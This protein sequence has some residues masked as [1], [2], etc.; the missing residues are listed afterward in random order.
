MVSIAL[1]N[2]LTALISATIGQIDQSHY[3]PWAFNLGVKSLDTGTP[4]YFFFYAGLMLATA[5][6]FLLIL[7]SY[8]EKTYLQEE[9]K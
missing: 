7:K 4:L 6:L 2:F 5:I 8:K 9:K 3:S 1:G